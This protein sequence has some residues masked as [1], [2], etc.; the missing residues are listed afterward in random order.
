MRLS[1]HGS[2]QP[3]PPACSS[4]CFPLEKSMGHRVRGPSGPPM[5]ISAGLLSTWGCGDQPRFGDLATT[6]RSGLASSIRPKKPVPH[7]SG[8]QWAVPHPLLATRKSSSRSFKVS[9][10]LEWSIASQSRKTT[11]FAHRENSCNFKQG[12]SDATLPSSLVAE[13]SSQLSAMRQATPRAAAGHV[14]ASAAWTAALK[15]P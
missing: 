12:L 13:I 8:N 3:G 7:G 6:F 14:S 1:S 10:R 15:G 4:G 9:R 5:A 11:S 2:C